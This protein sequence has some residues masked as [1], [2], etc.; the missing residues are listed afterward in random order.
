[1][2]TQI[3]QAGYQLVGS[4]E[5]R[6]AHTVAAGQRRTVD[7]HLRVHADLVATLQPF[8]PRHRT[9]VFGRRKTRREIRIGFQQIVA[10]PSHEM[11]E[12]GRQRGVASAQGRLPGFGRAGVRQC[13]PRGQREPYIVAGRLVARE[14]LERRHTGQQRI[15]KLCGQGILD[16]E[17]GIG[18][19]N[20][21]CA[22]YR[23]ENVATRCPGDF[24]L[25]PSS[26]SVRQPIQHRILTRRR[27]SAISS[28]RT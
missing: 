19:R 2:R 10:E 27:P 14:H 20:Q 12:Q 15:G 9:Q 21:L 13:N 17:V 24:R 4:I 18:I 16:D 5:V 3:Q 7:D 1:M 11:R 25:V 26:L 28:L 23:I 8:S 6:S 22:I